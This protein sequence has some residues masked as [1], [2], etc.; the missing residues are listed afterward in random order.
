MVA[1]VVGVMVMVLGR[2]L[3]LGC[4]L[5][6]PAWRWLREQLGSGDQWA[7]QNQHHR[8]QCYPCQPLIVPIRGQGSPVAW[9]AKVLILAGFPAFCYW[10]AGNI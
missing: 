3:M 6:V 5:T 10:P 1:L 7:E 8:Q 2:G 4:V 9:E